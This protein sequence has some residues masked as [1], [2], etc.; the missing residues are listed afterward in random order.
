MSIR[1]PEDTVVTQQGPL[2]CQSSQM[3]KSSHGLRGKLKLIWSKSLKKTVEFRVT[4]FKLAPICTPLVREHPELNSYCL[5][6]RRKEEPVDAVA[7]LN[8]FFLFLIRQ[9]G[10][11]TIASLLFSLF[12]THRP[13]RMFSSCWRVKVTFP[14]L[15]CLPAIRR[16][17]AWCCRSERAAQ[18]K[19]RR[20]K[21]N[22][23]RSHTAV[24][25]FHFVVPH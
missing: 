19:R 8:F 7:R 1:I 17:A 14:Y 3:Q 12:S 24:L 9:I 16:A 4:V 21:K 6:H 22:K 13:L 18:T 25:H 20:R 23:A 5:P 10:I 11:T 15:N 2:S